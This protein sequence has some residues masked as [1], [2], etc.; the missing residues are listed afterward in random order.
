MTLTKQ[1]RQILQIMADHPD[2]TRFGAGTRTGLSWHLNKDSG[3]VCISGYTYPQFF[4]SRRGLI[5]VFRP[6]IYCLTD[7]GRQAVAAFRS[8]PRIPR[9]WF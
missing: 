4:L 5:D 7:D 1:Q 6:G 8:P 3:E 9:P 2:G